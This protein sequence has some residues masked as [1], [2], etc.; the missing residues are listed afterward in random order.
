[1]N[2]L[3]PIFK[4]LQTLL[5]KHKKGLVE[6]NAVPNSVA[7]QKK[8]AYHLYGKKE[9]SI[10]EGRKPQQTYVAGIIMQKN[11]VG[12]YFMPIYSHRDQF[13]IQHP[14]LKKALKGKSCFNIKEVDADILKELDRLLV[15]GK[16]LYLK[17]GWI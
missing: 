12:F 2:D 3:A 7:K 9:V 10:L 13:D 1:M 6:M 4:K 17:L 14:A 8:D 16:E 15:Q 5:K 11:F